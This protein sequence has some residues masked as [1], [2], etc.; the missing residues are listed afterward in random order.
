MADIE[1]RE[2][3]EADYPGVRALWERCE[4]V[5]LSDSD[6]REPVAAYLA[7]NPG[8]SSV[9]LAR[10]GRVVGA[11]LCGDDGRR[12]Y[13]HHLAVAPEARG[14][15]I[16]AAL[17]ERCFAELAARG[18]PKCNALLFEDNAAGRAFWLHAGWSERSDLAILQK[19]VKPSRAPGR[20]RSTRRAG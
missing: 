19:P 6:A 12:G 15:G 13:L 18:I 3:R 17:L 1:L 2:L 4:G 5:G 8:M 20:S 10:D 16:A 11:V 9:A 7:R 14:L